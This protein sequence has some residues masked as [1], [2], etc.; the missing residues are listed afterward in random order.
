MSRLSPIAD[1]IV[2]ALARWEG[3]G[4]AIAP[5]GI[6]I[7]DSDATPLMAFG[8]QDSRILDCL[9]AAV[10]SGWNDLPTAVQRGIFKQATRSEADNPVWFKS[11][12]A[13]YLHNHK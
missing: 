6:V 9:G 12:V 11:R 10:V 8:D 5:V 13:R 7:R 4:G 2:I 3:E 1:Q